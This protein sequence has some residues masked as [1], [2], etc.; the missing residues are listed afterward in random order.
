MALVNATSLIAELGARSLA[1]CQSAPTDGLL[2]LVRSEH[3]SG[4]SLQ[5][6]EHRPGNSAEP[7]EIDIAHA[8]SLDRCRQV[9]P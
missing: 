6:R 5:R 4:A 3:S 9:T 2:G 1:L 7:R 8:R